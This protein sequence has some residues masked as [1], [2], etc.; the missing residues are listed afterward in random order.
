[1]GREGAVPGIAGSV[2]IESRALAE[3]ANT[4]DSIAPRAGRTGALGSHSAQLHLTAL[5]PL[6]GASVAG[7]S[8]G[9]SHRRPGSLWASSRRGGTSSHR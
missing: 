4:R 8:D 9:A 5:S 2:A 6:W 3:H 1:M 7:S